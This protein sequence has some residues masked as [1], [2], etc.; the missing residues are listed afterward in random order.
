MAGPSAVLGVLGKHFTHKTA[1]RTAFF[2]GLRPFWVKPVGCELQTA[3]RAE[4]AQP[5]GRRRKATP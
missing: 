5:E 1:A 3:A 4:P 2:P